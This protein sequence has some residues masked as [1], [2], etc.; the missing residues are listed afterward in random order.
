MD[1]WTLLNF[2]TLF[3][4]NVAIQSL[5]IF[6]PVNFIFHFCSLASCIRS[7]HCAL[8][9]PGLISM[10]RS[11]KWHLMGAEELCAAALSLGWCLVFSQSLIWSGFWGD[12]SVTPP[13]FSRTN[14]D[15]TNQL[16]FRIQKNTQQQV[17]YSFT[18]LS[19]ETELENKV[20]QGVFFFFQKWRNCHSF[21]QELLLCSKTVFH[22]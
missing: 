4:H 6:C 11:R 16:D 18:K 13:L 17:D 21:N 1:I 10:T 8:W 12:I 5:W 3:F 20:S 14:G 2:L 7:S 22:W 9:T 19:P 15:F